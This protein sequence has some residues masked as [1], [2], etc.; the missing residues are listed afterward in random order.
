VS[1]AANHDTFRLIITIIL[2]S[3]LLCQS[4]AHEYDYCIAKA[5][6]PKL[7]TA[8]SPATHCSTTNNAKTL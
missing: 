6:P 1:G 8:Q 2:S 4:C 3:H 5:D 7:R